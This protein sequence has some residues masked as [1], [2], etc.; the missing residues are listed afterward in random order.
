MIFSLAQGNEI[1]MIVGILVIILVLVLVFYLIN[2]LPVDGRVKRICQ[3][4]VIVIAII[5]ML[6]LILPG[7]P[8]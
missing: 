5:S 3:I 4:I 1:E 7:F 8:V 2:L 6:R